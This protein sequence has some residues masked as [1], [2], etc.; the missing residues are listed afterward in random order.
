MSKKRLYIVSFFVLLSLLLAIE[1]VNIYF[2]NDTLEY[3]L[4]Y[5]IAARGVGAAICI[6]MMAYCSFTHLFSSFGRLKD[7]LLIIPCC[8]IAINNFPFISVFGGEAIIDTK[9]YFVVLYAIQCFLVGLFEETA[10]RGCVFM[11]IL[12]KKH[13]TRKEIFYSIILSSFVFGAIHIVNLF[14][15]AG[16]VP[17]VLQL[18][19]SFLIGAMCAVVLLVTKRLWIPVII[20]AVFNFAGGLVPTLGKGEIWPMST[21][22]LT[23]VV[24]VLVAAY[25]VAL[26]FKYDLSKMQEIFLK[27]E[28][29][30]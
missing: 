9:W 25:T 30:K 6:I 19:Y 24:S 5:G 1:V 2:A 26:F 11:L 18:G 8:L 21:V 10:F 15:G 12:E 28:K 7:I 3:E 17:V 13:S 23:V 20:H 16:I 27:K 14:V 29:N 22:I 4:A